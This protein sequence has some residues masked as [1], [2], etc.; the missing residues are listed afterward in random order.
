M[1]ENENAAQR[2]YD[3]REPD[4]GS[5]CPECA[6]LEL[7]RTLYDALSETALEHLQDTTDDHAGRAVRDAYAIELNNLAHEIASETRERYFTYAEGYRRCVRH[8]H[9]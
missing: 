1:N 5:P 2:A 4:E 7:A 6:Q 9:T 8:L 3:A